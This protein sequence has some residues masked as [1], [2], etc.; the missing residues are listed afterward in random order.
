MDTDESGTVD[1]SAVP[2]GTLSRWQLTPSSPERAG[3]SG[4]A[5]PSSRTPRT[6]VEVSGSWRRARDPQGPGRTSCVDA[7]KRALCT[8]RITESLA[9]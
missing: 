6:P 9:A 2:P 5:A 1:R 3:S 7:C 4:R 8:A